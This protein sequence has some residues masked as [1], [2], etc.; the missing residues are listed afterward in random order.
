MRAL[1]LVAVAAI[2]FAAPALAQ[3]GNGSRPQPVVMVLADSRTPAEIA[4]DNKLTADK[5][6]A[7]QNFLHKLSAGALAEDEKP[8]EISFRSVENGISKRSISLA[9]LKSRV[10]DCTIE[11][12]R[13]V[14]IV[15]PTGVIRID[16]AAGM[17]CRT[18]KPGT[19]MELRLTFNGGRLINIL[20]DADIPS[21]PVGY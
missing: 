17:K 3:T 16:Y 12:F 9:E 20:V 6:I 8:S 21:K 2:V 14:N 11:S 10:Q 18:N 7:T 13:P 15:G 19:E 1:L 5:R 4:A